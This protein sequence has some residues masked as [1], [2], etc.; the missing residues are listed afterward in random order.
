MKKTSLL[1][2]SAM[3]LFFSNNIFAQVVDDEENSNENLDSFYEL[4]NN[5]K[6]KNLLFILMCVQPMLHGNKEYGVLL[7]FVKK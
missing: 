2:L 4:S 7:I 1:V 6:V 3:M 5:N